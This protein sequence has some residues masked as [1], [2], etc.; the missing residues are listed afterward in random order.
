MHPFSESEKLFFPFVTNL[1]AFISVFLIALIPCSFISLIQ[2]RGSVKNLLLK[3]PIYAF[4]L[5][6]AAMAAAFIISL[7]LYINMNLCK[8]DELIGLLCIISVGVVPFGLI[9]LATWALIML[10]MLLWDR[11]RRWRGNRISGD[12][13]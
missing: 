3:I 11:V 5:S 1:T 10:F 6:I 12:S 7:P 13:G 4:Y 9:L 8:I 2:N